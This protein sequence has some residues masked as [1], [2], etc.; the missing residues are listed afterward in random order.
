VQTTD[1]FVR[2]K[3]TIL[4]M[5]RFVAFCLL[6][7]VLPVRGSKNYHESIADD[8]QQIRK[9]FDDRL[10]KIQRAVST[11][12]GGAGYPNGWVFLPSVQRY[13]RVIF[14]LVDW[15]T[16]GERCREL[17][18]RSH[19]AVV[20][21]TAENKAIRELLSSID[22]R[23]SRIC[24]G[25]RVIPPYGGYWTSGQRANRTKCSTPW[26]WKPY[27]GTSLPVTFTDFY[28]AQPNCFLNNETCLHYGTDWFADFRWNDVNCVW[29]LCALCELDV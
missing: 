26:V 22:A 23:L 8:L 3:L 15:D 12:S 1:R 28:T 18:S 10:A 11:F 29:P 14:E 6:L 2:L 27:P 20:N 5:R 19:L 21:D 17:G 13:Y 7:A 16:A 4:T 25:P 24:R 9:E